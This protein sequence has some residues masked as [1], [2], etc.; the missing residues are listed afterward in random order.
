M[1]KEAFTFLNNYNKTINNVYLNL[2]NI[3]HYY[4]ERLIPELNYIF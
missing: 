2:M 4:L 1:V 3:I